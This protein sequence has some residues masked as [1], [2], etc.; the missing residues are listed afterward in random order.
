MIRALIFDF[1]GLILDTEG[2]DYRAWQEVCS[3]H[4]H[5]LPLSIWSQ[6]IGRSSDWFDPVAWLE[7]HTGRPLDRA[8][9]HDRQRRRHRELLEAEAILPGIEAYLADARRLGLKL[10]VASSSSRQWVAGH[11]ERLGLHAHWECIRCWGDVERAKPAPDLYLAVLECLD[12]G[13]DEAIAFE[14]SPNGITA[15]RGAGIVCVAVPNPLTALLDLGHADLQLSSL[16]ELPLPE[17]LTRIDRDRI[18]PAMEGTMT[19]STSPPGSFP[20]RDRP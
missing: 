13:P 20:D 10:G 16:G 6:C 4:G 3:E 9:I 19:I 18:R 12:V 1:D 17:L 11:L 7:A 14:D 8:A 2:P 15:A 5:D